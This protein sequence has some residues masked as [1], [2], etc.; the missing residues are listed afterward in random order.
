M[1]PV[2]TRL[3]LV[4]V[5]LFAGATLFLS[6]FSLGARTATTPGTPAGEAELWA[7]FWD[8][9]RSI[10]TR[11]ALGPVD[12]RDLVEG[13]ID[14]MVKSLGDPYS[15]YYGPEAYKS[16]L[17]GISGQFEGIGAQITLRADDST[18]TCTAVDR[19]CRLTV[20]TPLPDSPAE[21]A[22]LLA[23]DVIE[24]INGRA[25]V[26]LTV[27]EAT[28]LIRGP[29]G[30]TVRLRVL[31]ADE[32]PRE[33]AIVR[34]VIVQR[35]VT[36]E[37]LADG[38]V[39][40]LRITGMS[41][42]AASALVDALASHLAA[43]RRA[44]ILDLRGNPGGFITAAAR[45]VSQFVPEGPVYWTETADGEQVRTDVT[46]DGIALDPSI[47]LVVLVDRGSA[48][49]SEI[50]AGALQDAGRATIVGETTY[51]K[52]TV[53]GWQPL[54][55]DSG[56]FKMTI[57]KWLTRDKHWVNEGGITPDV[58]VASEG[59]AGGGSL[60]P[61]TATDPV[62]R[63]ALELLGADADVVRPTPTRPPKSP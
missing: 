1:R 43:G 2:A 13:A 10:T 12:P 20:V 7:P 26:G 56:G 45:I 48:S 55:N 27:S 33:L 57:A 29:K 6:G 44:I 9:Y 54:E 38:S 42:N 14:G 35:E 16:T 37:P 31:R 39:G 51:G 24:A 4:A 49:A 30:T 17:E 62:L 53:Q 34:A 41:D 36:S 23:D 61:D 47:R 22:G 21:S 25:V 28:E 5:A 32:T 60:T 63:R 19:V 15:A 40:Y 58:V 50:V 3:V 46:G 18:A 8:T 11:Y 59:A 52:G